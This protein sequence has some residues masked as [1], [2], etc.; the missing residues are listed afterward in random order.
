[1]IKMFIFNL[2][3]DGYR[4]GG[5]A[6]LMNTPFSNLKFI[7]FFISGLFFS[8]LTIFTIDEDL[9]Y[10]QRNSINVF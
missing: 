7:Y 9:K 3:K 2:L 6:Y 1:M 8:F 4:I 10:K 5:G